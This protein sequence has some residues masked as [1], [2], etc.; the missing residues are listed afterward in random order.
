MT[1]NYNIT[2]IRV[3]MNFAHVFLKFKN[4]TFVWQIITQTNVQM[5]TV[6]NLNAIKL[7][8][9]YSHLQQPQGLLGR[10][11]HPAKS[12]LLLRCCPSR[13]GREWNQTHPSLHGIRLRKECP[14]IHL[15]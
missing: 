2:Y 11:G 10:V 9:C 7:K 8:E 15:V 12:S 13:E 5:C 1:T 6:I 14:T 3:R 4:C